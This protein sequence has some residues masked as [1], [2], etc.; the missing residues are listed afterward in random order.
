MTGLLYRVGRFCARHHWPVIA[1]WL[2]ATIALALAGRAVGDQNNDN[3]SLPG[4]GSTKAQDLL[5]ESLPDQANGTN[6]IVLAVEKGKLTDSKNSQAIG[7]AVD[8]LRKDPNVRSAISPLGKEGSAALSKDGR[9]GYIVVTLDEGPSSL[10]EDQA[11]EV[12]DAA[13]PT[14]TTTSPTA[15]RAGRAGSPAARGAR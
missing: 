9:I 3:L 14:P 8:D 7:K 5:Q 2:V 15:G 12:L 11:Q 6:P 4:T 10:T 1:L 13:A